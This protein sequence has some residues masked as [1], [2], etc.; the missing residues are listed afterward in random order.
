MA[1]NRPSRNITTQEV[2]RAWRVQWL[3]EEGA[4]YMFEVFYEDIIKDQN[5]AE[6]A[7]HRSRVE[8]LTYDELK[9][10][11]P[12]TVQAVEKLIDDLNTESITKSARK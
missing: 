1:V 6:L 8:R 2:A 3:L 4:T 12:S 9:A 10:R 7:R 11:S 5:G